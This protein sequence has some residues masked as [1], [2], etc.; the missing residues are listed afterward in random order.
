MR[1]LILGVI[2]I[3]I[4]QPL[5]S[6]TVSGPGTNCNGLLNLQ[7][8]TVC[9]LEYS[10]EYRTE[11][12]RLKEVLGRKTIASYLF[13]SNPI[14]SGYVAQR[15][16]TVSEGGFLGSG[17]APT[18]SNQQLLLSQEIFLGNKRAKAQEVADEEYKVQT[19]R[20]ETVRRN[21]ISRSFSAVLRYGGFK[22]EFLETKELYELA[23]D[24]RILSTARAKEGVAPAMD[25]DVAKAEELRLWKILKQ[26]ERKLE[27]SK[28]DL[29]ILMNASPDAT[30]ELDVNGLE[31][32]ELPNDVPSLI[33][34]ALIHRPEIEVSENE[35]MLAARKLEQTRLQKIPNLTLGGFVQSDGFNEKVVG[36]QVSFPFTLWRNYEGEIKSADAIKE[37]AR[38]NARNNERIIRMEIVH[39]VSNYI[40]LRSEIEQYDQSYLRD[41]DRDLELLKE[42]IRLGRMKVADALNSQRILANAKL[43]FIVS[44]TEYSLSQIEL[45]RSIGLPFED[46]LK[47]IN[48]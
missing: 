42:A 10:P 3:L 11:Q 46:N 44:K 47:E 30:I 19:G 45:I 38:E 34:I 16:G 33:K 18:A 36:A 1:A 13:P 41:L 27:T 29:L 8:V 17:P 26:T 25:V 24:L 20:L 7:K 37:Q 15:K 21:M 48:P 28:G 22:K 14:L 6:E 5:S 12:L 35:I 4:M 40:A 9:I 31:L 23:K 32:K 2:C 43:N 39:A